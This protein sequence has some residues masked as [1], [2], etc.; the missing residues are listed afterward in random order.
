ML[1]DHKCSLAEWVDRLAEQWWLICIFVCLGRQELCGRPMS[2]WGHLHWSGNAA[3]F[4]FNS[5]SVLLLDVSWMCTG[6]VCVCAYISIYIYM[7]V[8][9]CVSTC[10]YV[11]CI[12]ACVSECVCVWYAF[13]CIFICVCEKERMCCVCLCVHASMDATGQAGGLNPVFN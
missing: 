7:C 9:V 8:C 11:L 2:E 1:C 13:M 3:F 4:F 5:V 10:T 6:F 12:H